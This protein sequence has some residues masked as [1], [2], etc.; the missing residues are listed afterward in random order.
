MC[1]HASG[2]GISK[3]G[4]KRAYVGRMG[5]RR[6]WHTQPSPLVGE[7]DSVLTPKVNT[8]H[9]VGWWMGAIRGDRRAQ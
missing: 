5:P 9:Q 6:L 1:P 3:A 4:I 2:Q 7:S 8:H